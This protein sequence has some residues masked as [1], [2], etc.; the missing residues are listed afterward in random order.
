M[1][2]GARVAA[3]RFS[4]AVLARL[5]E[6]RCAGRWPSGTARVRTGESG[7]EEQGILVRMQLRSDG[8]GRAEE[9]RFQAFGC[10]AAIACA[11]WIAE[12]AAGKPFA[13]LGQLR[14]RQLA[15]ELELA[16]G[17]TATAEIALEA[18][19]RALSATGG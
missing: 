16:P 5:R 15:A 6:P 18:L 3:P 9:A 7:A 17:D 4:P 2:A 8:S 11:S 14:A 19:R 12:W 1:R 10:P 13:E